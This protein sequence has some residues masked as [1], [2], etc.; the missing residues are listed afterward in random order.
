MEYRVEI[1]SIDEEGILFRATMDEAY[2]YYEGD[3][4][5]FGSPL[6]VALGR[7]YIEKAPKTLVCLGFETPGGSLFWK[8]EMAS[9]L[10]GESDDKVEVGERIFLIDEHEERFNDEFAYDQLAKG[11]IPEEWYPITE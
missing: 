9:P 8:S 1:H 2:Y 6:L 5:G 11:N 10:S 3:P 4:E 7:Y